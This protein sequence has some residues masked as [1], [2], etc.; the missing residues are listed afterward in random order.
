[1]EKAV[2]RVCREA[3]GRVRMNV[4]LADMNVAVAAQDEREVE[5]LVSGLPCFGGAQLAVDATLRCVCSADGSPRAR[6][7]WEDAAVLTDAIKDKAEHYPELAGGGRC[8]LIVFPV[9][10]GGRFG[11]S[12]VKFMRELAAAKARSVPAYLRR[13]TAEALYSRWSRLVAVASA[14]SWASSVLE[15]EQYVPAG[16]GEARTPWLLDVMA[17]AA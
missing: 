5:I 16:G 4:R 6:A 17:D 9:E 13:A 10:V 7:H 8:Q 12:A 1:M 2:A 3:G 11:Q 14:S 15:E